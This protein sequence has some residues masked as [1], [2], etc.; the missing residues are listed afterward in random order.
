MTVS[1]SSLENIKYLKRRQCKI[2]SK[3]QHDDS[4]NMVLEISKNNTSI[5]M[6]DFNSFQDYFNT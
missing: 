2:R 1:R 3:D 5:I 6:R 4:L